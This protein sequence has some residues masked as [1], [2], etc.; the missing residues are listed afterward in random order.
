MR[1]RSLFLLVLTALPV[2]GCSRVTDEPTTALGTANGSSQATPATKA[3]D[4]EQAKRELDFAVQ[5]TRL[6]DTADKHA[7]RGYFDEAIAARQETLALIEKRYGADAWQARSARLAANHTIR[8]QALT[9]AQRSAYLAT[10]AEEESAQA[11][12]SR[13]ARAVAFTQIAHARESAAKLWGPADYTVGNLLDQEA[14]WRQ[15][16]GEYAASEALARQALTIRE[17]L[18]TR[19][20]PDTITSISRLG[21]TLQM[22]K[23][24]PEAEPLLQEAA[25]RASALWG[26]THVEYARHLNNLGMLQY[27]RAE[28]T[29]AIEALT[30]ALAIRQKS[31]TADDPLV[32]HS[33]F[34]LGS[35]Y[36]ASKDF[37]AATPRLQQA[38]DIFAKSLD[39]K[40]SMTRLARSNLGMSLMAEKKYAEAENV[41]QKDFE[42]A[43]RSFGE[44]SPVVAEAMLRLGVLYGNQARFAEAEP[45]IVR[46]GAIE[47]STLGADHP[48][49]KQAE[50]L[51]ER[52]RTRQAQASGTTK[53]GVVK[54]AAQTPATSPTSDAGP[55]L[56]TP[57]PSSAG[58]NRTP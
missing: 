11:K 36:Y 35:A 27:D 30:K 50:Q 45:L 31:L 32:A 56:L 41:F 34:N 26:E 14:E 42:V 51:A 1:R 48:A 6:T 47:R 15:A 54:A 52:L 40:H 2:C 46:A 44:N 9:T 12:W 43:Q 13:G 58:V 5:I 20:H 38:L 8:L 28:L 39:E 53:E 57:P 55:V 16:T 24:Y 33:L 18:F 3:A 23:R 17:K 10:V 37:A 25:T 21:L 7:R 49:T 4:T 19:D 29:P 22:T